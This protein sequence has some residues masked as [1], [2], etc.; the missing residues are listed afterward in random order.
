MALCLWGSE[1]AFCHVGGAFRIGQPDWLISR[2]PTNW[3]PHSFTPICW[4]PP[5][6]FRFVCCMNLQSSTYTIN[7]F[8]HSC[9]YAI[10]RICALMTLFF[11]KVGYKSLLL[12]QCGVLYLR[13]NQWKIGFKFNEEQ[14]RC[15]IDEGQGKRAGVMELVIYWEP[16]IS[17]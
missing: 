4:S 8:L 17:M 16:L 9:A 7:T 12:L 13:S 14:S 1:V 6:S 11:K 3:L 10:M 15:H 2:F 5:L